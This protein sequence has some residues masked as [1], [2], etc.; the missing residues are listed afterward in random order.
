M[1][2]NIT[3]EL[4]ELRV[5]NDY[6]GIQNL[7]AT[8]YSTN[9]ETINNIVDSVNA[10]LS[11]NTMIQNN[12]TKNNNINQEILVKQK[13]LLGIKNDNL[14]KQLQDLEIIQSNISN[15]DRII[16][17]IN[18]NINKQQLNI[19]ILIISI[20]LSIILLISVF[21]YGN[22][23]ININ[24]LI[25]ILII[26]SLLYL[27]L[28]LYSYNIFYI[29]DAIGYL[30][31]NNNIT[32][33]EKSLKKWSEKIEDI[34]GNNEQTWVNDNCD[35]PPSNTLE[36][37][38][39]N[40]N[41]INDNQ[42]TDFT[43]GYYYNDGT[44]PSQLLVPTPRPSNLNQ[45]I[46]WVDYSVNGNFSYNSVDSEL[47]YRNNNYYNYNNRTN[48]SNILINQLSRPNNL[49]NNVTFTGNI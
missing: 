25:L 13:E 32:R 31:G 20:I 37:E 48:P 19:N 3:Q 27:S 45:N 1:I 30:S 10:T 23:I 26:I 47:E 43:N 21:L 9:N 36:E 14:M 29:K 2:N 33:L 49:V 44:A 34:Y 15:K 18:D 38:E 16:D 7:N 17:Q 35:C 42:I 28:L 6:A 41:Y 24:I 4:Q 40:V 39:D 8:T 12:I 46:E 11:T 5:E 22:F